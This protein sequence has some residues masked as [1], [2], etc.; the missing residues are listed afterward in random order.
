MHWPK[1]QIL[2]TLKPLTDLAKIWYLEVFWGVLFKYQLRFYFWKL[3]KFRYKETYE[4]ITSENLE[5]SLTDSLL[6]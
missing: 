1:F 3:L 4:M 5:H 2:V 6:W